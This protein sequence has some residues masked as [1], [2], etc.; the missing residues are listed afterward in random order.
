MSGGLLITAGSLGMAQAPSE[1]S[2]QNSVM[3]TFSEIQE[4]GTL[5]HLEDKKGN[6]IADFKPA[7]NF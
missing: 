5:V 4:A 6:T 7:K 3:M 2:E 1:D